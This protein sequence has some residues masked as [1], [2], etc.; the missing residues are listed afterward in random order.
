ME[1]LPPS[2][3]YLLPSV[4]YLPR[5]PSYLLPSTFCLLPPPFPLLPSAFRN[6][7]RGRV[8]ARNA[9][10]D[11][12]REEAKNVVR[13]IN[14]GRGSKMLLEWISACLYVLERVCVVVVCCFL[15]FSPSVSCT[16][17]IKLS[18]ETEARGHTAH[19]R[20]SRRWSKACRRQG[21]SRDDGRTCSPNLRGNHE[22]VHILNLN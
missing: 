4:F 7:S 6:A 15:L 21:E 16:I 13:V 5:S 12:S 2:P 8:P 11:C 3:F 22:A 9:P 19:P 10:R 18:M 1:H 14:S 17:A 20:T